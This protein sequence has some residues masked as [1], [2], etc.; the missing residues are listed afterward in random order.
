[1]HRNDDRGVG[2]WAARTILLV[3]LCVAAASGQTPPPPLPAPSPQTPAFRTGTD[4]VIVEATIVDR[5]GTPVPRL[6]V[7]DFAVEID[8]RR[9]DIVSAEFVSPPAPGAPAPSVDPDVSVNTAQAQGR[10]ILFVIDQASLAQQSRSVLEAAR[11]W[12]QTL[13]AGDRV[14][15]VALP[16]PGPRVEPTTLHVRVLEALGQTAPSEPALA[17]ISIRNV[18]I[19]EALQIVDGDA[20]TRL[21]VVARECTSGIDNQ[22]PDEIDV[23]SND[24]AAMARA[25]VQPVLSGLLQVLQSMVAI[26]GPKHIVL[27][28][29]GWP[30]LERSQASE[31]E[32]LATA[33]AA[34]QVM[35]HGFIAER[36]A[37][38]ASLGRPS[39]RQTA[40]REMVMGSVETLAGWTGGQSARIVGT[41]E[42]SFTRLTGA[43]TGY[44]RL[45]VRPDRSD[46]DGRPHRIAVTIAKAGAR[47]AGH[48]RFMA[49]ASQSAGAPTASPAQELRQAVRSGRVQTAFEL[50]AATYVLGDAGTSDRMRIF[51]AGDV[52]RASPG[53]GQMHVAF[54]DQWGKPEA[55]GNQQIV[56]DANGM[57]RLG[58]SFAVPPGAF[59][60]RM[61][62][63]DAQGGLGTLERTIDARWQIHGALRASS[64]AL[65][66]LG[67]GDAARPQPI[68]DRLA[69][70]DRLLMQVE[71]VRADGVPPDAR[72]AIFEIVRDGQAEP[73]MQLPADLARSGPLAVVQQTVPATLL[74]PGDYRV[75]LRLATP[76]DVS[77]SRRV[78]I[79]AGSAASG[80]MPRP[81]AEGA[82]STPGRV[83]PGVAGPP[84][85]AGPP[86]A[87][88]FGGLGPF[89]VA[90]PAKFNP[91]RAL[92][93]GMVKPLLTK[94]GRR[95]DVAGVRSSLERLETGPWPTETARGPL[96]EA[97]L[98]AHVVAGLG[99]MRA[100]DFEGAAN[101]F[102]TAL[103]IAP[104]FAPAMV[105]LAACYAAGGKDLEAASAWQTVL[106]REREA[107]DVHRLA[108]EAWLRADRPTAAMAL[109]RQARTLWPEDP[110]FRRL[111]A[112]AALTASRVQE[113]IAILTELGPAVDE[114]LLLMGLG[115]LYAAARAGTPEWDPA[116]DL[117]VMRQLRDAYAQARGR[118]LGLVDAWLE[119]LSR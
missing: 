91:T 118:S 27:V 55:E 6:G 73:L 9:R 16:A 10:T 58:G 22:C 7:A 115:S 42:S 60:M 71:L 43:L 62:V 95:P 81:L 19:W 28:S 70:S 33:A 100:S 67:E 8:G 31:I 94:L 110:S 52:A 29:A 97:P 11:R 76:G 93:P 77:L 50:R 37:F 54:F 35:V 14:G 108:I 114:P 57:G 112:V 98:A 53:P 72:G 26:P 18:S 111:H 74:P 99:R 3:A 65:F 46:L 12:V 104:D 4:L 78:H 80:P 96:A 84:G 39:P 61:A 17:F 44:Y 24:L 51:L 92:E 83:P 113:G 75:Q 40:D 49:P 15:L 20:A 66:R 88:G 41:G 45:A 79:E 63:R 86:R 116:R 59:T 64:L 1:M 109:A 21:Q 47:V 119:D 48:R 102:R 107:P 32:P 103:R 25:R 69:R 5:A 13:A 87:A 36:P 85:A 89:T 82:E 38:D 2:E 56:V 90:R 101:D 68:V 106:L 34:A 117:P 105:Y 30:L 23:A